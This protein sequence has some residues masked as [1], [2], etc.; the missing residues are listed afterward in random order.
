MQK[1]HIACLCPGLGLWRDPDIIF[2][3]CVLWLLEFSLF[4]FVFWGGIVCTQPGRGKGR[5]RDR[6]KR[7]RE[8][9]PGRPHVQHGAQRGAVSRDC[10]ITT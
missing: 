1:R 3:T 9:I 7:E 6:R 4:Y 8:R 10:E 2:A 5:E